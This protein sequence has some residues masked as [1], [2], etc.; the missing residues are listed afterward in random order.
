MEICSHIITFINILCVKYTYVHVSEKKRLMFNKNNNNKQITFV[1]R[2]FFIFFP[3]VRMCN[4]CVYVRTYVC[5]IIKKHY[6]H[7]CCFV[8]NGLFVQCG[9]WFIFFFLFFSSSFVCANINFFYIYL[10]CVSLWHTYTYT[11]EDI[12]PCDVFVWT[13][14]SLLILGVKGLSWC[15]CIFL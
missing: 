14:L 12:E 11:N 10:F 7:V 5:H 4:A 1:F 9:N 15:S 6:L 13:Q 3:F 8:Q 2:V